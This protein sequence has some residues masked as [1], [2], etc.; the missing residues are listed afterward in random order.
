M[1]D[2]FFVY[3]YSHHSQT[4]HTENSSAQFTNILP[5]RLKF[6]D[7]FEVALTNLH[8]PATLKN[9]YDGNCKA[10]IKIGNVLEGRCDIRSGYYD[11]VT[12]ILQQ[13]NDKFV[14]NYVFMIQNDKVTGAPNTDNVFV[15][16]S[17]ALASILGYVTWDDY[18]N[19][20]NI[21]YLKPDSRRG[22]PNE[23]YVHCNITKP[24][25][26]G[27]SYKNILA[28]S[29]INTSNVLYGSQLQLK[30]SSLQYVPI[31]VK[32]FDQIEIHLTDHKDSFLPFTSGRS[33]C[34]LHFRKCS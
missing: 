27:E 12:R 13:L 3:L 20:T 31:C 22:L 26:H 6:D 7:S 25:I 8:V 28:S 19:E 24:Q 17:P 16:L 33:Y 32:E 29:C 10:W 11:D 23:V 9:V 18:S 5:R 4:F 34:S 1:E 14:G 21:S 30:I 15:K 2:S